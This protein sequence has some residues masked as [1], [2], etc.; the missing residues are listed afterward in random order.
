MIAYVDEKGNITSTPP[1]PEEKEEIKAEDIEIGSSNRN[2]ADDLDPV[3]TGKVTYFNDSRGYGFIEDSETKESAFIHINNLQIDIREG[4]KVT[5]E[6]E[7]GPK[8]LQA[9]NV[10]HIE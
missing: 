8:G 6:F 3:R 4:D 7:K 10:K 1:D 5:F 2:T 9:V